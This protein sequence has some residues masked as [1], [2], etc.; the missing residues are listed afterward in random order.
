MNF[1]LYCCLFPICSPSTTPK[2][3]DHKTTIFSTVQVTDFLCAIFCC[4]RRVTPHVHG[5]QKC[6]VSLHHH[7]GVQ[8]PRGK[9][10]NE[11]NIGVTNEWFLKSSF[12][13]A[14]KEK[15]VFNNLENM[16]IYILYYIYWIISV[17]FLP[18]TWNV[19]ELRSSPKLWFSKTSKRCKE[20]ISSQTTSLLYLLYNIISI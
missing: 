3:K 20:Y 2:K 7:I 6:Q 16:C 11:W 8:I 18:V 1:D 15:C 4:S 17:F 12:P 9:Q 19:W 14:F 10:I 13:C 5:S